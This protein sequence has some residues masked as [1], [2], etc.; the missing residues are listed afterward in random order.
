MP[1]VHRIKVDG[2]PGNQIAIIW[3]VEAPV[4]TPHGT[5]RRMDAM[6]VQFLLFDA[7]FCAR[8]DVDGS[9]GKRS[10]SFLKKFEETFP[11]PTTTPINCRGVKQD[12]LV[13]RMRPGQIQGSISHLEYK[14]NLLN[15]LYVK[16]RKKN[17]D[18][19]ASGTDV[20]DI[21]MDRMV[22]DPNM[23]PILQDELKRKR[24]AAGL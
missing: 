8:A 5:N 6:L 12:G 3:N 20:T 1:A 17:P 13:D 22:N 16:K 21:T 11:G 23:P 14:M 2:P 10:Q 24:D 4:G 9:W 19:S 15:R 7:G 18:A